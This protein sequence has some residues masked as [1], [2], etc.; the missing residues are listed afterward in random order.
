MNDQC[1]LRGSALKRR[2]RF[3]TVG[4][5]CHQDVFFV[6]V[7]DVSFNGGSEI[8][9]IRENFP[10][11]A[12]NADL[13]DHCID[14]GGKIIY[15]IDKNCHI[16]PFCQFFELKGIDERTAVNG[17]EISV[18]QQANPE[19]QQTPIDNDRT[20]EQSLVF[21][22]HPLAFIVVVCAA[23][24]VVAVCPSGEEHDAKLNESASDEDSGGDKRMIY[25]PSDDT[26]KKVEEVKALACK[27]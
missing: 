22:K 12:C 23:S 17:L 27:Y 16:D 20:Y 2:Y 19:E 21:G 5:R 7:A 9:D 25:H 8:R 10:D 3:L 11:K 1:Q 13:C 18:S 6:F 26:S 4:I 14:N 15:E 24:E